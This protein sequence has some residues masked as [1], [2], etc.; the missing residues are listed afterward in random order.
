MLLRRTEKGKKAFSQIH[1]VT[2]GHCQCWSPVFLH[3]CRSPCHVLRANLCPRRPCT[4]APLPLCMGPMLLLTG[5]MLSCSVTQTQLLH[6]TSWDSSDAHCRGKKAEEPSCIYVSDP[7]SVVSV[8]S[9]LHR[10][11]PEVYLVSDRLIGLRLCD[12]MHRNCSAAH[13]NTNVSLIS[14]TLS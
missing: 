13:P 3:N 8:Q 11:Y 2:L 9:G 7:K 4:T 12:C 10:K 6:A 14:V 5:G 1:T